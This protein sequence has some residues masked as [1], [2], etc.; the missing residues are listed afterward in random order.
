MTTE[1]KIPVKL[2]LSK[3]GKEEIKKE[4]ADL[5]DELTEIFTKIGKAI[6]ELVGKTMGDIYKE[7]GTNYDELTKSLGKSAQSALV[8]SIGPYF[9]G[10]MDKVE[11]IWDQAW[12]NMGLAA[13]KQLKELQADLINATVKLPYSISSIKIPAD[14]YHRPAVFFVAA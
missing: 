3:A 4:W 10:E 6:P 14:D 12:Q 7:L 1:I 9:R 13:Q 5:C 11:G 2:Q 8:D